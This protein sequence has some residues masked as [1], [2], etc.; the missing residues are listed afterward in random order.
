M[1]HILLI[2]IA[3]TLTGCGSVYQSSKVR[4][5]VNTKIR[6]VQLTP[7]TLLKANSSP[8][9][10]KIYPKTSSFSLENNT[11]NQKNSTSSNPLYGSEQLSGVIEWKLPE[12]S[13]SQPYMI[14]VSDVIMLS[15]P[16]TGSIVEAL[17]GTL[18]TYNRRK[19]FTVQDDGAVSVPDIGRIVVAGLTLM[20][21]ED[22]VFRKLVEVGVA[23]S[24][25]IEV[26]EFNSQK[27]SVLGAVKYPGIEP[28]A[29]QP[30]YIDQ[31]ISLKGG[32]TIS[33]VSFVVIRLYRNGSIY[34]ISGPDIY[35][36][37]ISN[38]ILLKNGD[39]VV[40][41]TTSEYDKILGLRQKARENAKREIE[42]ESETNFN[43]ARSIL[44]RLENGAISRDYVYIIGEVREQSRFILPFDHKAFLA[45]ALLKSGGI[46]SFSGSPK[47]I[48]VLRGGMGSKNSKEITAF[49]LDATNVANFLL[50]THLELRPKDVVFV[51]TQPITN[52][53]RIIKQIIPT[54]QIPRG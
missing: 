44:N 28:I 12:S 25:S 46:L 52:W 48:Y 3:L 16:D 23:P 11:K 9:I 37:N 15:T 18:A 14:G 24:F 35:K 21:A 53:N 26:I 30:L 8:Y 45:D 1:K 19:E 34:Q 2:F 40:V 7:E 10:P 31:A 51:G 38:K 6:I 49:H 41:D 22:A 43:E 27:V 42:L 29:M 5:D 39:R 47:Q 13:Q 20:E 4:E 17:N 32:I 50:A 54:F 36:Q 33:D